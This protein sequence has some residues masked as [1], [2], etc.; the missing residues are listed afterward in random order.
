LG[1]RCRGR[2]VRRLRARDRLVARTLEAE[3]EQRLQLVHGAERT[4]TAVRARRPQALTEQE[5]VHLDAQRGD[6]L[7]LRHQQRNDDVLATPVDQ[8]RLVIP[9]AP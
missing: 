3:W 6:L 1:R 5:L 2:H 8:P 7:G 9:H 4:L